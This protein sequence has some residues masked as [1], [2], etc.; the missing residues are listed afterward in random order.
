MK[1]LGYCI[2]VLLASAALA[3]CDWKSDP[4]ILVYP[5]TDL[6]GNGSNKNTEKNRII[7]EFENVL[8]LRT[9]GGWK[10]ESGSEVVFYVFDIEAGSYV[11]KSSMNPKSRTGAYKLSVGDEMDLNITFENSDI[12]DLIGSAALTVREAKVSEIVCNIPGTSTEV[13]ILPATQAELDSYLTD[14]E[15]LLKS[16]TDVLF[17][18][19]EGDGWRLS[20]TDLD[21]TAYLVL[22]KADGS[23]IVKF[24][25]DRI[26]AEGQYE[27]FVEE[28]EV[29]LYVADSELAR[30]LGTDDI[31]LTA[32]NA[33]GSISFKAGEGS[34]MMYRASKEDI[35]NLKSDLEMLIDKIME[36]GY[37]SKL[38]R[39]EDGTFVG[40]YYIDSKNGLI[41]FTF[42]ADANVTSVAPE[43]VSEGDVLKFSAPVSVSGSSVTSLTVDG[44]NVTLDGLAAGLK[45]TDNLSIGKD[46]NTYAMADYLKKT[47][48]AQWQFKS[49]PVT[50]S[51]NLKAEY[52]SLYDWG[53]GVRTYEWNGDWGAFV[54][55]LFDG[56]WTYYFLQYQ[57]N[58]M[59]PI[60]G[61][62]IIRFNKNAGLNASFGTNLDTFK[63]MM[64]KTYSF[65]MDEDHII[66]RTT[67]AATAP[68]LIMSTSTNDFIYFPNAVK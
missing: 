38:I 8:S 2:S 63:S 11:T 28:G 16:F 51:N 15:K 32:V 58:D 42:Y 36:R 7:N 39:T 55:M 52:E 12:E 29:H 66:V 37:G 10:I 14:D 45:L 4:Q 19:I 44:D 49:A 25:S 67:E 62:D 26:T 54:V 47:S 40:H 20:L 6:S 13:R 46:D 34:Y 43:I 53:G 24:A 17:A 30:R 50:V 61:T 35:D 33:D 41:R 27:L 65:L 23:F 56:N 64:G 60:A 68:L 22:N 48:D 57:G 9:E 59:S 5:G 31:I 1:H 21:E 3:S 18:G